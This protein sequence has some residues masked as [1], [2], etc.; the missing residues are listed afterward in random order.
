MGRSSDSRVDL[1]APCG[2]LYLVLSILDMLTQAADLVM[3]LIART[4]AFD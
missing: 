3:V 1:R 4:T 2:L